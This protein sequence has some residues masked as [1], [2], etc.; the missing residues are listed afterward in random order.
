MVFMTKEMLIKKIEKERKLLS[1]EYDHIFDQILRAPKRSSKH[2]SLLKEEVK[3]YKRSI[4]LS[5]RYAQL[6]ASLPEDIKKKHEITKG[7]LVQIEYPS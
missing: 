2:L 6:L 5:E 3:L 1:K 7:K 4:G